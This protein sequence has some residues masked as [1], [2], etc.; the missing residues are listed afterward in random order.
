M[1]VIS[2][3]KARST[4]LFWEKVSTPECMILMGLPG[5]GKSFVSKY[6]HKKYGY[7]IL[8][9]ENITYAIFGT[10]ICL[11]EQYREA[12]SIL[13]F[14]AC[15]LTWENYKIVIDA[16]NLQYE[17]R[18]QIYDSI[19]SGT[20]IYG[21]YLQIDESISLDRIK[22]RW[23]NTD[24]PKNILSSCSIETFLEFKK[25]IDIPTKNEYIIPMISDENIFHAIDEFLLTISK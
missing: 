14:L 16:T 20:K 25:S 21:I 6:L 5:T 12:Y 10:T 2:I 9:W 15:E 23:Q 11:P 8:S 3:E 17:H 13:H 22:N 1:N 4:I 7:T 24:S 18:K 19:D